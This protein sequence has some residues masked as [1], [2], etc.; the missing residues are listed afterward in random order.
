MRDEQRPLADRKRRFH[1]DAVDAEF[2]KSAHVPMR[3]P[4][5]IQRDRLLA[6]PADELP[7]VGA[8]F[9]FFG[10]L[11]GQAGLERG[12]K[13]ADLYAASGLGCST[14]GPL[15]AS[16]LQSTHK[17]Q[18]V[19]WTQYRT[20]GSGSVMQARHGQAGEPGLDMLIQIESIVYSSLLTK[21][22]FSGSIGRE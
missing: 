21:L 6:I 8:D 20:G 14:D 9:A 3:L 5:I 12:G 13:S 11:V 7:L 18:A 15:V 19:G 17:T 16:N 22:V 1:A 4:Q 10:W 2:F